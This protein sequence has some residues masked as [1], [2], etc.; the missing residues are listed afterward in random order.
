[1]TAYEQLAAAL[2]LVPGL[3]NHVRIPGSLPDPAEFDAAW[4][5][6]QQA[7][8]Q[9]PTAAAVHAARGNLLL[10]RGKTDAAQRSYALAA[11]FDPY[12]APS[13]LMLGE[14]AYMAGDEGAA[15]VWFDE[16]FALT[17]LY[18][19]ALQP[20]ARS[21]LVLCVAGPWPRNI[22]LDFVVDT[23]RWTL[24]RWYLPDDAFLRGELELP[25]YELVIDAIGESVDA[26]AALEAADKFIFAQEMPALNDPAR[27]PA[28]AR[29]ALAA[30]LSGVAGCAVAPV[31]RVP[32]AELR[33][34]VGGWPLLVRPTDS[35]GGKQLE[36]VDDAAALAAY[37][38]R[39]AAEAYDV[40]AFTDYR[41]AD[42]FYRKYRVMFVDGVPYPYHLALD[43]T[44]MIHYYRAPMGAHE[45]M[46][47]EERRFL[48]APADALP[49]WDTTVR[50]I[51]AAV[52]LDYFGIDCTVLADGTVFVFEADAA[53]LVHG[54]DPDPD[55]RAAYERIRTALAALL[56]AR[57][58]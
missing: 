5:L 7:V 16:A 6:L 53:M 31:Q 37:A 52:G 25:E 14:L 46:R 24:H 3:A 8:S 58:G 50:A 54:F 57:A 10:R 38:G 11:R 47:D 35:H 30:T 28:T 29:D 45:W 20:G 55:K 48:S 39:V 9:D 41:S 13:R 33:F 1:M 15:R 40:S 44:W 32:A 22:P 51:G 34:V 43:E 2:A 49:G 21:A 4:A 23:E 56:E 42:G 27:V 17:H 12:D 18:S 36:R 26:R 19:P